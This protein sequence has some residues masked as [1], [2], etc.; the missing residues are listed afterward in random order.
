MRQKAGEVG[1]LKVWHTSPLSLL[2]L[3]CQMGR[4]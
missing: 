3:S 2:W 1:L 4:M